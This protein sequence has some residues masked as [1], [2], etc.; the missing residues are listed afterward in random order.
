[1]SPS[2]PRIVDPADPGDRRDDQRGRIRSA[3][4]HHRPPERTA[5]GGRSRGP[6]D[7]RR[8][9][10]QRLALLHPQ[11]SAAARP[12]R[13][14]AGRQR[15]IDSRRR[16]SARAGSLRRAHGLQRHAPLPE[17]GV[18]AFLQSMGVRFGAHINANTS[19]DQTVYQLQIPTDNASVIDRSLLIMEDW[20]HA[21]SFDPREIEKERGVILEEWRRRSGRRRPDAGRAASRPA[22]GLPLRRS[23]ADRKARDHPDVPLRPSEEVLHRLV[24]ARSHGRHRRRRFRSVGDRDAHQVALR[25]HPGGRI[26]PA[27]ADLRRAR[28]ARHAIYRGHRQRGHGHHGQRL[29][30]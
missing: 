20:A 9:A 18:I 24:S 23:A 29:Q 26:A 21:V 8:D 25:R 19:F 28:S 13:A 4:R 7:H 14:P 6:A 16:R 5:D 2:R 27:A 3:H 15:G 10:A 22:Q 12:R 30:H 1:M 11:E 17:A